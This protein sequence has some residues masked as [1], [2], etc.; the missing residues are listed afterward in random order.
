M[1]I[2]GHNMNNV[3]LKL[4]VM[5]ILLVKQRKKRNEKF[6]LLWIKVHFLFVCVFLAE[7]VKGTR[8]VTQ[9]AKFILNGLKANSRNFMFAKFP[10]L[11]YV[12]K[13]SWLF[14]L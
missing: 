14:L 11:Q 8:E 3:V 12:K 4:A 13:D 10:V 9:T 7:T 1:V 5:L 2:L 6:A